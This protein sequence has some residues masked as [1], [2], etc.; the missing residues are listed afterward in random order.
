LI[1]DTV[2][3]DLGKKLDYVF[4]KAK[5]SIHNVER[6]VDMERQLNRI[7]IFDNAEG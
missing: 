7:G 3:A 5:G 6:S 1:E 4:G 2:K